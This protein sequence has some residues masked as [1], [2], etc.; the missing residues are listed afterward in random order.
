[1]AGRIFIR[2]GKWEERLKIKN[3]KFKIQNELSVIRCQL[4]V[5]RWQK[6]DAERSMTGGEKDGC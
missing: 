4:S 3:S 1:M 2:Y 5:I 6:M